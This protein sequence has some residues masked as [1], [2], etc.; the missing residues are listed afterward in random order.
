LHIF[1]SLHW[2]QVKLGAKAARS[3]GPVDCGGFQQSAHNSTAPLGYLR[4][5]LLD[6]CAAALDQND[7]NDHK[8]NT[9][10][11]PDNHGAVHFDFPF[12]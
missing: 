5:L 8:Q 11:N 2:N 12:S 7:Q 10:N 3:P 9:G 1:L 6:P 4:S